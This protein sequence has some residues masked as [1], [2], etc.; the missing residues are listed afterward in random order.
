M[1]RVETKALLT[2]VS[3]LDQR[4]VS[5][6]VVD[7]WASLLKDVSRVYASEAVE[8]HFREKPDT[9]L[10]VGHVVAGAKRAAKRDQE[11][12]VA[13]ARELEESDWRADPQPICEE[14]S[15]RI[16]ECLECCNRIFEQADDM[17]ADNRHSWAMAHVYKPKEAW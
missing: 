4:I 8:E 17:N 7:A 5:D 14:H 1:D 11:N 3:T 12:M 6:G 10:N 16:L 2:L 15:L 13:Q 9:Y